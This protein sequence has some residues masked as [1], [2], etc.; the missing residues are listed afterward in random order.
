MTFGGL[1][2]R[3]FW[4]LPG[5]PVSAMVTFEIFVRP[6][7][8][9]FAGHAVLERPRLTAEAA[10]PIRS[11]GG[12]THFYR[13]ALDFRPGGLPLARL[14]GPQ[15]SGLL[16][17]MVQADG[18]AILPENEREI[19]AGGRIEVILLGAAG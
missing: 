12:L 3:P 8:R 13:V 14:T 7:L 16:T 18:L 1:A 19:P 17:S 11:P 5:N 15:G 10:E 6:A 9:R 2:G 4:G